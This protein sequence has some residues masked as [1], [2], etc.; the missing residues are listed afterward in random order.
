MG[1]RYTFQGILDL[2]ESERN[3]AERELS[4]SIGQLQ[5]EES[6]LKE[7]LD[8]RL[9]IIAQMNQASSKSIP[10]GQMVQ[11]QQY[12]DHL[13][14]RIKL[15][16]Q[17][18][19]VAQRRVSQDQEQLTHCMVDEKVWIKA[20]EKALQLYTSTQLK[21]EQNLLDEMAASRFLRMSTG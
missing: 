17:D 5:L 18:V 10:I 16:N 19:R 7:L 13:D 9:Q 4:Q 14:N 12:V 6:S 8:N 15:K 11:M 1:F 20:R 3:Q 2:K 21:K